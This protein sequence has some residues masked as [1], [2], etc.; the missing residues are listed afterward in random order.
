MTA[1]FRITRP[2]TFRALDEGAPPAGEVEIRSYLDRL[3]KM[4][5]AE[6]VGLYL[7][8]KGIIPGGQLIAL[9]VWTVVCLIGVVAVRA[10]GTGDRAARLK[11]D[12]VHVAISAVAFVLWVYQMGGPFEAVGI[13]VPYIGSLL[14]LAWT[15]FVPLFYK[16]PAA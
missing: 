11:P 4:I 1:P 15:F 9:T 3:L 12:W 8:G 14:M 5:P 10:Y 2:E 7:I 13:A 6:V 16:G